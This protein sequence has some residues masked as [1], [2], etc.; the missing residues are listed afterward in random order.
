MTAPELFLTIAVGGRCYYYAHSGQSHVQ[1]EP[2]S[3]KWTASAQH[4]LVV[5]WEPLLGAG[6]PTQLP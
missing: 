3:L 5:P 2:Q 6:A 4:T 1:T